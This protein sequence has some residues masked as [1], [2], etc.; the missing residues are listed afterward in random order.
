MLGVSITSG[1]P[2]IIELG[3]FLD[4]LIAVVVLVILTKRMR[5]A[6]KT[7]D[8]AVLRKLRG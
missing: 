1:L 8:T 4:V 7:S 6:V 3:I 5:L 2:L